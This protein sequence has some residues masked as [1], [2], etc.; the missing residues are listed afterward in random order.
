MPHPLGHGDN[1][2]WLQRRDSNPDFR[3]QRP[4]SCPFG[5]HCKRDQ[6]NLA[7]FERAAS[8]FARLRSCS[9]E[10]QVQKKLAETA[11]LEL[12]R[13]PLPAA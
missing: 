1:Q 10:L 3:F 5:R 7:R 2:C 11:R 8:T 4:A 9:A 6:V 12:T 13:E